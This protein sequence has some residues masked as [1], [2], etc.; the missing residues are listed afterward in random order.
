MEYRRIGNSDLEV[1]T[2][3]LGSWVFGGDGWGEADDAESI[4][5]VQRALDLGINIID[6]APIY[7]DGRAEEVIG[8]ALQGRRKNVIIATKCGLEKKGKGISIDL[9]AGFI[10]EEIE[11]SL[12]RLNIETIDLYQ[13]HW[14]DPKTPYGET[15]GELKKLIS[16]GKIRHIGVSNFDPAQIK[17]AISFA[18][19]I[20]DQ[21]QYSL[22]DRNIEKELIPVCRENNVSILSYGSLGGGILTGKYRNPPSFGKGDVR[23]FFYK[24]YKEPFWGQA[25]ELVT[26]LENISSKRGVPTSQSAINWVLAHEEVAS[27]IVGC[28]TEGQLAQNVKSPEWS[29]NEEE[30][31]RITA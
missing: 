17:K 29:L 2:V 23:S 19:V 22:F 8:K 4:K 24:F 31:G 28:R 14:P 7:G 26:I 6:T 15:F 3:A 5:V 25:R 10:R 11:N 16:E 12:R 21:V 20:S 1:S 13:C 27:C 30:I 9:T 18:P